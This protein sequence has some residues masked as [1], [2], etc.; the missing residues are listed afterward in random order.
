MMKSRERGMWYARSHMCYMCC[1]PALTRICAKLSHAASAGSMSLR[2]RMGIS[3]PIT[4]RT[5]PCGGEKHQH[6]CRAQQQVLFGWGAG[7]L[8]G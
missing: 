2:S 7:H 6:K 1:K 3:R 4:C 5:E 8:A